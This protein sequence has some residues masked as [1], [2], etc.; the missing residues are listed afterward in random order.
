MRVIL[1]SA[2]PRRK[3]LFKRLGVPFE[4]LPSRIK[5][6]LP[7]YSDNPKNL[8]KKIALLKAKA[9]AKK[10][11]GGLVV[12]ADTIVV[13]NKK[14]IGKPKNLTDAKQILSQLSG[15][16]HYVITGIAII[17][18]ARNKTRTCAVSTKVKMK[19]MTQ[20]QIGYFAKKHLDKAGAYAVQEEGDEFIQDLEGSFSN[21]VGLP[22]EKL[23]KI[24]KS[25]GL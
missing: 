14:I 16:T 15:S 17:D 12:G 2:S 9:V 10:I 18:T 1:A 22:L 4:V 11:K 19:K 24:F 21:V 25:I 23:Q 13:L 20:K 5:E 3:E 6:T 7:K 8:A